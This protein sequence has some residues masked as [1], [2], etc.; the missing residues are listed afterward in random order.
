MLELAVKMIAWAMTLTPIAAFTAISA[1]MIAGAAKDDDM[2]KAIA[3]LGV[4]VFSI[5]AVLLALVYFT[6]IVFTL[7]K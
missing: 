1:Y 4:S 6:D 7:G 5:G 3:M 2:I